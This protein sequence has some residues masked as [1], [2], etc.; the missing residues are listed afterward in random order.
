MTWLFRLLSA[1]IRMPAFHRG[2]AH[3]LFAGLIWPILT[4]AGATI[5]LTT[6]PYYSISL[7]NALLAAMAGTALRFPDMLVVGSLC[8]GL[9]WFVFRRLGVAP[10]AGHMGRLRLVVEPL[11]T[12]LAMVGGISLWYPAVLSQPLLMP[13]ATFPAAGVLLLI[14][15]AVALGILFTGSPGKRLR[16]AAVLAAAGILSPVPM[17]ARAALEPLGGTPSSLVVLGID[18]I[19][20]GD[21]VADFGEW[22]KAR[23]G[24][25]YERAVAPGL[26]TNAVWTSILTM[27]PV[28]GHGVFHG[29]QHFPAGQAPFIEAARAR[30]YRTVS[31]FPDQLTCAVGSRAGFDE[32]RSGPVGWRQLLLPIVANNSFLVPVVAHVLP[33]RGALS[34]EGG[35]F[36]YDVRRDIR[37]ILRSGVS[38]QRTLVAAHLTYTHLPAYPGALELS[39]AER[40]S[41]LRAPA[42]NIRDRSLDWQDVDA[43]G[44]PLPLRGWKVKYLQKVIEAEVSAARYLEGGG[45]LVVFSDH[46]NRAGMTLENFTEDRFHHVVLA[47]FG[48]RPGCPRAPVSLIDIA[49]MVGLSDATAA[50]SVEFVLSAP[51]QWPS[52]VQSAHVRWSGD[53]DLNPGLLAD[54]FKGLRRH[55][56]WVEFTNTA[57]L[58][59]TACKPVIP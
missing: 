28:R 8:F 31:R 18:S 13:V 45:Q 5:A 36:S 46:G 17:W 6:L 16:L 30:G 2:T 58:S 52:L 44:D 38:G 48:V 12:F 47:T 1:P 21:D 55:D 49:S 27:Q 25:W 14:A 56:P 26:L 54:I 15:A 22:V 42:G 57:S 20:H 37:T 51:E 23:G 59:D 29:F 43:P 4:V 11:V 41:V 33:W 32:D 40:A 35:T 19:S 10:G 34:N 9:S 53:V 7:G 3:L 24:T 50:P 39:W